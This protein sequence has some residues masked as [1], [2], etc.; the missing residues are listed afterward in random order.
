ML[1]WESK[2]IQ[3]LR[4]KTAVPKLHF[5]GT[6]KT[7]NG[8][9]YLVMVM[10]LLG[11]SLEDLMDDWHRK[12]DLKTVLHVGVQMIKI[13]KV[14]HEERIIHRDIKPDNFLMGGTEET[15]N[16]VYII[17]F[18][19]SKCYKRSAGEH[20]PFREV[21]NLTCTARYASINTHIGRE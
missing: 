8:K 21:K 9:I 3:K 16:T 19:L 2:L 7:D 1:H 10:D 18:G 14:V 20:I 4:L 15:K 17:D 11:K 6:E 5:V 12:F 13:F